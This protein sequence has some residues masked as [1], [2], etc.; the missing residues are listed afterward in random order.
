MIAINSTR[1]ILIVEDDPQ[2]RELYRMALAAQGYAVVA[3]EDGFDALRLI[4]GS[5]LPTAIVLD[6]EL[7]RVGGRDVYRELRAHAD[8]STIPILIVTG[9]DTS[10]LDLTDFACILKKPISVDSLVNAVADC[11]RKR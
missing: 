7:P 6:L 3:V 4:D 1:I 2:L 9:S 8:T 10:D 11:L 5:T